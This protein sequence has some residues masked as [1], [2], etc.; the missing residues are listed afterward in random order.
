MQTFLA[1]FVIVA[2]GAFVLVPVSTVGAAALDSVCANNPGVSAVCDKK[3][4]SSDGFIKNIVNTLLFVSG[5]VSVL[6][7]IIGGIMF[8]ISGGNSANVAKAK[9]TIL[10]AVIGLIVAILAFAIVNWVAD[11][12]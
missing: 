11:R 3:E 1:A 10:Y 6:A 4:D 8:V 2:M 12:F 5:L 9:N 7:I